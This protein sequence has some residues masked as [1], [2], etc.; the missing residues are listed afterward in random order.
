MRTLFIPSRSRRVT[1]ALGIV[2]A[3]LLLAFVLAGADTI[4]SAFGHAV[5]GQPT[6]ASYGYREPDPRSDAIARAVAASLEADTRQCRDLHGT[7]ASALQLPD[8]SHRCVDKHGR[9]LSS[10]SAISIPAH[11]IATARP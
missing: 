10:R 11:E 3:A 9:R 6:Y 7:E 5:D 8:G 4:V 2:A 1:E